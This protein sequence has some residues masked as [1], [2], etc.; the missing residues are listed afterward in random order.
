MTHAHRETT[1]ISEDFVIGFP[2]GITVR[3]SD[4]VAFDL[5]LVP[6]VQN[7]PLYVDL[8]VHPGIV[9]GLGGGVGTGIR[10]A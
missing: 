1:T 3:K 10:R 7:D 5:E 9:W 6:G 2:M 4:T 8:T